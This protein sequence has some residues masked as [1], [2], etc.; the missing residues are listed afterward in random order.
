MLGLTGATR[1][2]TAYSPTCT[3][4]RTAW[5]ACRQRPM[6]ETWPPPCRSSWPMAAPSTCPTWAG[7]MVRVNLF[8]AGRPR[9][10]APTGR[11][12]GVPTATLRLQSLRPGRG[13][14]RRTGEHWDAGLLYLRAQWS[15]P[16]AD[17]FLARDPY[18]G[19]ALL[20]YPQHAH[21]YVGN[22]LS[23]SPI[24]PAGL[25]SFHCSWWRGR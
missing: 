7:G 2:T 11:R 14:G 15:D 21:V 20:P 12:A 18:P 22:N 1:P 6:P 17:R 10:G 13:D 9:L 23:T 4:A 24:R 5:W 19:L 25:P 8:L 16:A 3:T